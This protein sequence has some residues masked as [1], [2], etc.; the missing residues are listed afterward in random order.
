MARSGPSRLSNS[1]QRRSS[2]KARQEVV[3]CLALAAAQAELPSNTGKVEQTRHKTRS[4]FE[5]YNVK[6]P[7]DLKN[8]AAMLNDFHNVM[9]T[10]PGTV[11]ENG[12]SVS[13]Q[14]ID[15]KVRARSS[16]G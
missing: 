6:S 14:V 16:A 11:G 5:R 12:K 1:I 2:R 4:A 8:D 7:S 9:G 3:A 13:A 10:N 15:S